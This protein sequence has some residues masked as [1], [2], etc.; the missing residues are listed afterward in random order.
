METLE[1]LRVEQVWFTTVVVFILGSMVGS[2]LNVCIYRLPAGKSV[3]FPGSHCA[4]G[5]PIPFYRNIPIFTWIWLRGV[6]PCCGA[7]FSV[8]YPIVEFI[9]ACAFALCWYFMPVH[10]ALVGWV[11]FSFLLVGT[12]ID[13]D[14]LILPD[15]TTLGLVLVGL[16]L[17]FFIPQLHG[18]GGEHWLLD[19]IRSVGV[20]LLGVLVGS[21]VILWVALTGEYVLKKEAI[22]FGDVKLIGGISAITGWQGGV[23]ALFGGAL[24]GT[25]LFLLL[26]PFWRWWQKK[27]PDR[28]LVARKLRLED[29]PETEREQIGLAA[30]KMIPFGPLI[31]A[32][33]LVYYFFMREEVNAYLSDVAKMIY[34]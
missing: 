28:P 10:E 13:W 25:A 19:G 15:S 31:S 7:K 27:H 33:G 3:V 11:L 24:L 17:S 34:G 5:A 2:F 21:A 12:W 4:C 26:F 23:F 14:Y 8:Q 9:T 22:G 1:Y 16:I 20:S 18:Y 32:G 6:A 30:G 29:Y